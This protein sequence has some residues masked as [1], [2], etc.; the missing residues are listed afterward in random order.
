MNE[1]NFA[2]VDELGFSEPSTETTENEPQDVK[3]ESQPQ[4]EF[5]PEEVKTEEPTEVIEPE[6]PLEEPKNDVK[7]TNPPTQ[8]DGESDI[9]FNLR[10]QIYDAGQAKAMAT[11]PEEKSF[12]S[13]H[14]KGLRKQLGTHLPLRL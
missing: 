4:V 12:L 3:F 5:K 2:N 11:D 14:I 1:D 7:V 10:K 9:Q 13:E 6:K 8:Y